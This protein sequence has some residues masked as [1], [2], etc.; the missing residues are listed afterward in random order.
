MVLLALM[1]L[2]V[3]ASL[4][5]SE[6]FVSSDMIAPSFRGDRRIHS[7]PSVNKSRIVQLKL[8]HAGT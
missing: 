8:P 3:A 4:A 6:R 1:Y 7:T 2:R 5:S